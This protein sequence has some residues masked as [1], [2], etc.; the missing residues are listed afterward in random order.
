MP[1]G[2]EYLFM[3]KDDEEMNIWINKINTTTKYA[4]TSSLSGKGAQ[5]ES[6]TMPAPDTGKRRWRY[7]TRWTSTLVDI[8][9]WDHLFHSFPS[10]SASSN[11][12]FR[13]FGRIYGQLNT[14]MYYQLLLWN[15]DEMKL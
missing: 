14:Y 4:S 1:N 3:A 7:K 13:Y 11:F 12:G 9:P 10:A 5:G 8:H 2:G 6:Q 15:V